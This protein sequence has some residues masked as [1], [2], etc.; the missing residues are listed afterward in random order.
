MKK[1]DVLQRVNDGDWTDAGYP[2]YIEADNDAEALETFLNWAEDD[3]MYL[4]AK[5]T[6]FK[7]RGVAGFQYYE[8]EDSDELTTVYFWA[9]EVD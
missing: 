1:F 9:A 2:G 3:L 6:D 8:S 4:C 7:C 5:R